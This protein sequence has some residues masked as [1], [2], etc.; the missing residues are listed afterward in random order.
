MTPAVLRLKRGRDARARVH[1]WIF[2]GDVADVSA[3]EPGSVVTVV[4]A[5]SRFVGRG[6]YNPRPALCC[7]VIT[8]RDEPV[9]QVL[10]R[11]RLSAAIGRRAAHGAPP[12]LARLVW[13]EADGLP[14][15]GGGR[16]RPVVGVPWPTLGAARRR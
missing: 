1:P 11:R 6:F 15:L 7:R 4:D 3:V 13:S 8:W 16:D 10:L 2:Q 12:T 5:G 14:R 9:G